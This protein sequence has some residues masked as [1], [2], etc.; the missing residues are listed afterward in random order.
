MRGRPKYED[1]TVAGLVLDVLDTHFGRWFSEIDL[2]HECTRVRPTAR[3]DTIRRTMQRMIDRGDVRVSY[4]PG[5]ITA[6]SQARRLVSRD[7]RSYWP[8]PI[9]E[10]A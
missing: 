7:W 2:I 1:G 3:P 9:E 10:T 6:Y 5:H 4:D 8:Q